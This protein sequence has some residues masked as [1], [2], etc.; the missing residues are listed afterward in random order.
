M[1]ET[2]RSM[3]ERVIQLR[4]I[5]EEAALSSPNF[6]ERIGLALAGVEEVLSRLEDVDARIDNLLSETHIRRRLNKETERGR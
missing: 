3:G 1:E 2:R 6:M 4:L 5:Q